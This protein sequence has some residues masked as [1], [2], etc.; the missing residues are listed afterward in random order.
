MQLLWILV[1]SFPAFAADAPIAPADGLKSA[2]KNHVVVQSEMWQRALKRPLHKRVG[3]STSLVVEY[4]ALD[5][6]LNGFAPPEAADFRPPYHRMFEGLME[7][8]PPGVSAI[9]KQRLTGIFAIK[10]LGT[11]GYTEAVRD[12][13]GKIVGAFIVLDIDRMRK[14]I[15]EWASEKDSSVFQTGEYKIKVKMAADNTNTAFETAEFITLHEIGHVLSLFTNQMPFWEDTSGADWNKYPFLPMSWS[16]P[17]FDVPKFPG[18]PAG[19]LAFYK[20]PAA[21]PN[22]KI[23][24]VYAWMEKTNFPTLYS[25]TNRNE[26]FADSL[27]LWVRSKKFGKPYSLTISKGGKAVQT[28]LSCFNG[29]RCADKAKLFESIWK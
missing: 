28:Y 11:T 27:A 23:S 5:N 18:R 14:P 26:D 9:L 7:R 3:G 4:L 12:K 24:E 17:K 1:L 19:D 8:I 15:N 21:I 20:T 13:T 6:Q 2:M 16:A 25:I 10:N 29:T 22:A